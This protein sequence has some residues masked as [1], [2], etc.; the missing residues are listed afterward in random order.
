MPRHKKIQ[1]IAQ[2]NQRNPALISSA[3]S[4]TVLDRL[5]EGAET[6]RGANKNLNVPDTRVGSLIMAPCYAIATSK[7]FLP[8]E[9]VF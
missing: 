4:S 2:R 3:Q 7:R 1:G 6:P 5:K 9:G 8:Y